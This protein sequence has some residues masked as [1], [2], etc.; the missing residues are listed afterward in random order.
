MSHCFRPLILLSRMAYGLSFNSNLASSY[1]NMI[2]N[3]PSNSNPPYHPTSCVCV[4]VCVCVSVCNESM[5]HVVVKNMHVFR[6]SISLHSGLW[7]DSNFQ[8]WDAVRARVPS[9]SPITNHHHHHHHHHH[10]HHHHHFYHESLQN[11]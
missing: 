9:P 3:V 5:D 4:C 8:V 2:P 10:R 1:R 7:Q 11:R 6:N